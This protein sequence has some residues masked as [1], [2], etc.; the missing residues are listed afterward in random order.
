MARKG[1]YSMR[2]SRNYLQEAISLGANLRS[3]AR[4]LKVTQK[5]VT[6]WQLGMGKPP[7]RLYEPVRNIAR[8]TVYHHLRKA[9]YPSY[10]ASEFRRISQPEAVADIEWLN[11]VV[12]VLYNDWN[13]S[14]RAYMANPEGWIKAHPNKKIPTETSREEVKRRIEKGLKRGRSKEE[15]ENY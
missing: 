2:I 3:V 13:L 1:S 7:K 15:I 5:Q 6:G 12:D 9:G 14:Y 11:R 4:E 10:K 8:R